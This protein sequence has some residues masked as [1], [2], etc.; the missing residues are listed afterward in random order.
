MKHKL[1]WAVMIGAY[2]LA[3]EAIGASVRRDYWNEEPVRNLGAGLLVGATAAAVGWAARELDRK[4][5]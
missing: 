4:E 2:A 3:A 5:S 1:A